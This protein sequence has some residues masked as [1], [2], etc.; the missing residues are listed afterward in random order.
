[1]C[2][3]MKGSNTVHVIKIVKKYI[4]IKNIKGLISLIKRAII[5]S[6]FLKF[7]IPRWAK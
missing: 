7:V 3:F 4:C 1:M 2:Y 6:I 5:K